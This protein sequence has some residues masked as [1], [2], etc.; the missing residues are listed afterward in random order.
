MPDPALED[1]E[2]QFISL[3][4]AASGDIP[5][6]LKFYSLER[7]PRSE[8]GLRHLQENYLDASSLFAD[9]LDGVIITGTEPHQPNLEHEPYWTQLVELFDWAAS[10]TTS[11]VLSCLAAHAAVLSG[12]GIQ[13]RPLHKK[14]LGVFPHHRLSRHPLLSHA[15]EIMPFPHS[16]WND[17]REQDLVDGGYTILLRSADAG[18]NMFVKKRRSSLF[19]CFQGHPEYVA[20]TL[21]LEYRRDIKRFLRGERETYPHAPEGYFSPAAIT[22]LEEF[23]TKALADRR[24]DIME[25]FPEDRLAAGLEHSWRSASVRIYRNW[26][27]FLLKAYVRQVEPRFSPVVHGSGRATKPRSARSRR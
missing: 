11:A 18:V 15:S 5:V 14:C 9:H 13:R 10:H 20:E 27:E 22:P 24:I 4:H 23:R 8:K 21:L 25:S 12:D 19:V 3:L 16:R 6:R 1:T 7:V 2:S 17:L 26:L